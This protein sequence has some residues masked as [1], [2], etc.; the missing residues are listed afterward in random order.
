MVMCVTRRIIY[1]GL[2]SVDIKH[3]FTARQ[4]LEIILPG[5]RRPVL[6]GA[7]YGVEKENGSEVEAVHSGLRLMLRCDHP[8]LAPGL[9]LRTC[10]PEQEGGA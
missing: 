5:L 3:R 7:D 10:L 8:E 1:S 2:W 9:F 6:S 4:P